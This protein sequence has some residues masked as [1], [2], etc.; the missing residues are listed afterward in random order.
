MKDISLLFGSGLSI[1]AGLPTAS[2]INER[3]SKI[4]ESD[5]Y[6]HTDCSA[7]FLKDGHNSAKND[8]RLKERKF[9]QNFLDFY[10]SHIIKDKESFNYEK[11]YDY[12]QSLKMSGEYTIDMDYLFSEENYGRILVSNKNQ[13]LF[14]FNMYFNQLILNLLNKKF[15]IG[16][17]GKPYHS[18]Y[19]SFLNLL[20][21]LSKHYNVN[22]HTLNHD[23]YVEHLSISDSIQGELDDGFEEINSPYF[24]KVFND[25]ARY[26]VRLSR[27]TNKYSQK[28]RLFKL[29]GS[30][31]HYW[32][33]HNNKFD[34]LKL[35]Y[36][37]SPNFLYKEINNEYV[38]ESV[39]VYPDF[40]SGSEYKI[41]KYSKGEYYPIV[42]NH[43]QNNL[44]KSD[45]L[46]IIGYG[47][48]D[49]EINNYILRFSRKKSN[50]VL[51]V[52][53]HKPSHPI[54]EL[55]NTFYFDGGV[56]KMNCNQIL[57]CIYR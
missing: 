23:L 53:I 24:G 22:M 11:F 1:H 29:H 14:E 8:V 56:E 7:W 51:V 17:L 2:K 26:N 3:L 47:F 12:Y 55:E 52:D 36:G 48:Q 4:D 37:I 15:K 18:S 42:F 13:M 9:I 57:S 38:R 20:E 40:L 30:I 27:F 32:F 50:K 41:G 25:Y 35:K 19:K 33:G 10:V 21:E 28:F 44:N 16:H 54:L 5:I 49:N 34:L 43:F 31:D 46:L 6:I 39:E 45:I